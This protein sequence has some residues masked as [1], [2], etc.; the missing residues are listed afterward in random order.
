MSA[1]SFAQ[2]PK[3]NNIKEVK[4]L[5][6]YGNNNKTVIG[7]LIINQTLQTKVYLLSY[8]QS[9]DSNGIVTTILNFGNNENLPLFNTD[10]FLLFDK[11]V[12]SVSE[13][14][15]SSAMTLSYSISDDKR[16]Y[17]FKAGQLNRPFEKGNI[18]LS[19]TITS[20]PK[21]NITIAKGVDGIIKD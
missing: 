20:Q 19:L 5:N 14:I 2:Q 3:V 18:L 9:K 13:Q 16:S 10:I 17:S 8:S 12:L 21:T 7:K 11:P 1:C 6:I 15:A 4:T